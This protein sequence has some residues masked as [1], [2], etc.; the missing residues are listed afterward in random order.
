M[1]PINQNHYQTDYTDSPQQLPQM[2]QTALFSV[3]QSI[4]DF[5]HV[6]YPTLNFNQQ[7]HS[8]DELFILF[9]QCPKKGSSQASQDSWFTYRMQCALEA[10]NSLLEKKFN[11]RETMILLSFLSV[12]VLET[13]QLETEQS[14][15]EQFLYFLWENFVLI[16]QPDYHIV[17][18][19]FDVGRCLQ[20]KSRN[21]QAIPLFEVALKCVRLLN[22]NPNADSVYAL[23]KIGD[24]LK[25]QNDYQRAIPYFKEALQSKRSLDPNP[26]KDLI[27]CLYSLGHCLKS[28]GCYEEAIPYFEE[29]L[30]HNLSLDQEPNEEFAELFYHIGFCHQR[31]GNYEKAIENLEEAFEIYAECFNDNPKTDIVFILLK[32]AD[33]YMK[34][35][36]PD[37][38][39]HYYETLM[40]FYK[41]TNETLSEALAEKIFEVGQFL[42]EMESYQTAKS[43]Y[44]D[45]LHY[46]EHNHGDQGQYISMTLFEIGKCDMHLEN[47]KSA[48][49]TFEKILYLD[50]NNQPNTTV[51]RT[52]HKM[53]TCYENIRAFQE[54]KLFFEE[55]VR[56]LQ[57]V[58]PHSFFEISKTL[59][60]VARSHKN[61]FS[62]QDAI[63]FFKKSLDHIKQSPSTI[64][65][66]EDLRSAKIA[67]LS[68]L[69]ECYEAVGD[70]TTAV[71]LEDQQ[72]DVLES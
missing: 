49:A 9:N 7:L 51:S 21:A 41:K 18:A 59:F 66:A 35:N 40:T 10:C 11:P 15:S 63:T 43:F 22:P 65:N 24:L 27:E 44:E 31:S 12:I 72:Y 32:L 38:A 4:V 62:Y 56:C 71:A 16:D 28:H 19:L 14:E 8:F 13:E 36:D 53:G 46:L 17:D 61:L 34:R 26:N 2:L 58:A 67:C 70:F 29:G 3:R 39:E 42:N 52:L 6:R 23:F 54:A 1:Q 5:F 50:V 33:C 30:K 69:I 20:S 48:I 55:S 47:Y 45:F 60:K 37:S 57:Q 68:E 25:D 64:E